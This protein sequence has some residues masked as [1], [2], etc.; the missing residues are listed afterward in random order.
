GNLNPAPVSDSI[1]DINVSLDAHL[2]KIVYS[3]G[4]GHKTTCTDVTH[5]WTRTVAPATK[6]PTCGYTYQ[7]PS[8]PHGN[9]TITANAIWAVDWTINGTTGTIPFYQ[10]ATTQLPVGEL[11]VLVR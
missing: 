5:P 6:S 10:S 3:M 9:Y 2:V 4:D 8:L 7:Q 1:Y 11:Q